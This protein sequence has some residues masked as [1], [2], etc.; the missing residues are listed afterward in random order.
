MGKCGPCRRDEPGEVAQKGCRGPDAGVGAHVRDSGKV[1][2]S[3]GL[4]GR[5]G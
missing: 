4:P 5:A 3:G 2:I 1:A